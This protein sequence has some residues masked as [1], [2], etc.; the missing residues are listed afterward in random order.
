MATREKAQSAMDE[1]VL[2]DADLLAN[3]EE[4]LELKRVLK[5]LRKVQRAIDERV[6]YLLERDVEDGDII[7]CGRFRLEG[8]RAKG[9]GFEVPTWEAV[10]MRRREVGS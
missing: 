8:R 3:L 10:V 6:K 2:E 5:R 9:G 4:E 7:R 1:H